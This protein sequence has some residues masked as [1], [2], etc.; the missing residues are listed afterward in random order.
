M[1]QYITLCLF[2][3]GHSRTVVGV[4]KL[5]DGSI[6]L[7]VLDPSSHYEKLRTEGGMASMTHI[8]KG[9]H[10][11]KSKQYQLVTVRGVM[12][13]DSD[14]EVSLNFKTNHILLCSNSYYH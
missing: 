7:L 12:T 6:W 5:S 13:S 10:M 8:R 11:F 4:E 14:F 2:L 9:L 1:G 3:L